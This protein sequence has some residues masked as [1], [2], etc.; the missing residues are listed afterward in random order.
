MS[1][2]PFHF[3]RNTKHS[4]IRQ[5]QYSFPE[6][7]PLIHNISFP[8]MMLN[9]YSLYWSY[10]YH[11]N[12]FFHQ[13]QLQF[14]LGFVYHL[15]C[16]HL[17]QSLNTDQHTIYY[18]H[19]MPSVDPDS[20]PCRLLHQNLRWH[21]FPLWFRS[22]QNALEQLQNQTQMPPSNLDIDSNNKLH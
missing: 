15:F 8:D 2:Q 16:L 13:T 14:H 19:Q 21:V 11:N 12:I 9:L 22:L 6:Q 5:D 7:S 3:W 4:H 1:N 18:H 17:I 10:H 20:C